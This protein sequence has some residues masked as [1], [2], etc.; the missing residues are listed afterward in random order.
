MC[1]IV[2]GINYS[3]ETLYKG[4]QLMEHRGPDDY[5][6]EEVAPG[7][8]LGHRRLAIVDLSRNGRQPMQ[9]EDGLVS[10]TFNGEIY[11][12]PE[13]KKELAPRYPFRSTTDTEVLLYGYVEWGMEGL[14]E[15]AQGMFAFA[16]YD[17][18]KETLYLARDR[19][20]KKPLF[21]THEG[22]RLLFS[23]TLPS[24]LGCN[25]RVPEINPLAL[26]DYL[27]YMCVPGEKTIFQGVHKLPPASFL[28]YRR[29]S[30][31]IRP[32]WN[33]SFASKVKMSE[34]EVLDELDRLVRSAVRRRMISDVPLGAFLSGGVDS[35][36]VVGVMATLSDKP[37]KTITMGF[38]EAQFDERAEARLV[39]ERWGTAHHE[40]VIRPQTSAIL[41]ELIYHAGEPLGDSSMLPTYYVAKLARKHLTVVL[42]GDGG[43]ELFAGYARPMVERLAS[44]YRSLVPAP[45]RRQLHALLEGGGKPRLRS[46]SAMKQ[47]IRAGARS[48]RDSFIFDRAL[49]SSRS[50]LYTAE[51]RSQLAGYHPDQ[52][53]Q[54]VWDRAEA[55][56]NVDQAMYGDLMTYLPDELL[57]KMDTMTMAHSLEARSPLL[58]TELAEFS[59]R[60]P[61]PLKTKHFQTKYLLKKLSERYV[62]KEVLYR[63]K[64]GFNMPMSAWLRGELNGLVRETLLSEKLNARGYFNRAV[65]RRWLEEHE[66]GKADHGQKLWS[67]FILELWFLMFVDGKLK[68]SDALVS[69]SPVTV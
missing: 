21:Y 7:L 24:L 58:D 29:G 63:P 3:L 52:V 17:Q 40:E 47:V 56:D 55:K 15:R 20:G 9:T 38:D 22:G 33:L 5:G 27:T 25:G 50:E 36:L 12:Y 42:N 8:V 30:C 69:A 2:G 19:F 16:L 54:A 51:Y 62:P 4:L 65:I 34:E 57:V 44:P 61:S 45:I 64:K 46:L 48:A 67:L 13:L 32:Y 43:D 1:G 59:A 11:N 10:I 23:S 31:S 18:R 6:L 41:P 14:L 68:R 60:I 37:V 53:Y 66:Q 49:R 28:T 26:D 39:S 35:S